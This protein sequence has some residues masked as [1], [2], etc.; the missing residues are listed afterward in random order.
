MG[1]ILNYDHMYLLCFICHLQEHLNK[2]IVSKPE[3]YLMH[4]DIDQVV[5]LDNFLAS[6][7]F[8]NNKN[9]KINT[10]IF[11]NCEHRIPT[12]GLSIGLEFLKKNL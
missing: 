3:I 2:N 1:Y 11:Q 7:E 8:F 4:G 9:I 5:P 10:K 6:K 12:E